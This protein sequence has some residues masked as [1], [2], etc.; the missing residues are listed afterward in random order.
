MENKNLLEDLIKGTNFEVSSLGEVLTERKKVSTPIE[1]INNILG[2][3]I[4]F[5]TVLQSF[6]PPKSG[7]STWT[8]QTMGLFQKEYP[9]GIS[10]IVDTE[11]SADGTRLEFLGVDTS[12][13]LRLPSSS[14]ED[15]FLSILKMLENKSKSTSELKDAP[16]FVIWDTISKG[17]AQAD[18]SQSRMNAMDR[19]RVIKNYMNPVMAEVGKHDFILC[20]LNQV[21]Y[22]T[23]SYG[24]QKVDSG[25]GV[26]K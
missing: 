11:S 10:V 18:S 20:L 1:V 26:A 25:G 13:V 14:I 23:D 6:G 3:G 12:K 17:L 24:N 8:Y 7:K 22:R 2:G 4:P 19:A 15:G 5:G 16:V 21:I 9:N